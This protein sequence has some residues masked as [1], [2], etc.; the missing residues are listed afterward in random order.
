MK[1]IFFRIE[2]DLNNI[3]EKRAEEENRSKA[4]FIKNILKEKLKK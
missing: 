2:D 4:N 3:I 1:A